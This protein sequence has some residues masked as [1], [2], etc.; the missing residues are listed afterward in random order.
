MQYIKQDITA[1]ERGVIAQGV[2]C[3]HAMGA[4][5]AKAILDKW[6]IVFESYMRNLSGEQMLGTTHLINVSEKHLLPHDSTLW[7]ANCYTQEYFGA[8]GKVY[9]SVEAIR[10]SLRGAYVLAEIEQLPL[11]LPQL[12]AGL[13]GLDWERDVEPI[14]NELDTEFETVETT[15]CL[16]G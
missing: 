14:I 9:A 10:S 1:I 5:V 15:I 7:V 4:G 3:Q 16:W 13:G 11:F 2:N 8:D 12:G 6:P